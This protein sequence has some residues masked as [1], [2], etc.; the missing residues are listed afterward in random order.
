MPV[1]YK[2]T[3]SLE[4]ILQMSVVIRWVVFLFVSMVLCFWFL[5]CCPVSYLRENV[6]SASP[7][8]VRANQ[9][10]AVCVWSVIRYDERLSL[11]TSA[12]SLSPYSSQSTLL[13]Q[14]KKQKKGSKLFW[15]TLQGIWK[16]HS[17]QSPARLFLAGT[18]E[19]TS[20]YNFWPTDYLEKNSYQFLKRRKG[21]F[22]LGHGEEWESLR[23]FQQSKIS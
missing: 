5:W 18:T 10:I 2:D 1:R 22:K 9:G 15:E 7:G 14:L 8:R 19:T 3:F 12:H 17:L 23:V 16:K 11:E 13:T 6:S 21:I 20:Q 4:V